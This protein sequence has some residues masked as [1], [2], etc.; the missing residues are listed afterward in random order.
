MSVP[1][2]ARRYHSGHYLSE[3]PALLE[4]YLAGVSVFVA[5]GVSQD[6]CREILGAAE[7]MK[8]DRE[9]WRSFCVWLKERWLTGVRLIIDDKNFGMF[10]T[11]SEVFPDTRYQR[12]T[13]HFLGNI[14]FDTLQ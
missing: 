7:G 9:S 5:I 1:L 10:E 12:C 6:G 14:F 11:F 2:I 4:M 13:V 8:E 3:I